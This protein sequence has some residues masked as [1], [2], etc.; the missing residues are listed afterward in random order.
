MSTFFTSKGYFLK[1]A[2]ANFYQ[3]GVAYLKQ[4]NPG[5]WYKCQNKITSFDQYKSEQLMVQ[6]INHLS[7]QEQAEAIADHFS[8]I[9]NLYNPLKKDDICVPPFEQKDVPVFQPAQIWFAL[10]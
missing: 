8:K 1:S 3:K 10:C 4:R 9:Q 6:E 7:D 5:E 2:K